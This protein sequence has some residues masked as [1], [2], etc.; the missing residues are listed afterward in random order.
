MTTKYDKDDPRYHR[1]VEKFEKSK[2]RSS[3]DKEKGSRAA[4]AKIIKLQTTVADL[5]D[6]DFRMRKLVAFMYRL[7]TPE[8]K[9]KT[10]EYRG[11]INNG[12]L[13]SGMPED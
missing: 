3:Q 6:R 11:V 1:A 7:L 10:D 5:S 2:R 4:E 9:A 8:Q 12:T 13:Y